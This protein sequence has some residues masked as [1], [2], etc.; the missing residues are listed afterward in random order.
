MICKSFR[1]RMRS[2]CALQQKLMYFSCYLDFT[3]RQIESAKV[4]SF[5]KLKYPR[6]SSEKPVQKR[7]EY[8]IVY[9]D[10]TKLHELLQDKC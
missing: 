2:I 6:R 1:K 8:L 10:A 5:T 7:I 4:V 9:I 3:F